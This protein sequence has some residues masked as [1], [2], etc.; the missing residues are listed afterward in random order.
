MPHERLDRPGALAER[1]LI[2]LDAPPAQKALPFLGDDLLEELLAAPL[3]RRIARGEETRRRRKPRAPAAR[4]PLPAAR[5]E[6]LVRNLDQQPGAVAGVVF[7]ST[8]TAM[9]H[10]SKLGSALLLAIVM[11]AFIAVVLGAAAGI[12]LGVAKLKK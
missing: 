1:A 5:N 7:T 8:C 11:P 4:S 9:A 2:G 3:G 12:R 6:E 10:I